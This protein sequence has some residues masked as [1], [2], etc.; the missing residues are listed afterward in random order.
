[1]MTAPRVQWMSNLF[2]ATKM[3]GEKFRGF[4][5]IWKRKVVKRRLMP[6]LPK[7]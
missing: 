3:T 2:N 5:N 4:V 6:V 7:K 1:M